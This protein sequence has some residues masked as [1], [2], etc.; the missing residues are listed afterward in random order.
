[1]NDEGLDVHKGMARMDEIMEEH[2]KIYNDCKT[3][4][5]SFGPE[6]DAMFKDYVY[7]LDCWI[8]GEIVYC[9]YIPKYFQVGPDTNEEVMKTHIVTL[10]TEIE[11]DMCFVKE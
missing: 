10:L 7:A 3:R 2:F 11:T 6:I 4:L 8:A 5:P 9:H 1:M